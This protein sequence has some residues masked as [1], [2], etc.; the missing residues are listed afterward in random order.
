[1][2]ANPN[3]GK[4]LEDRT[5]NAFMEFLD[6]LVTEH[7]AELACHNNARQAVLDLSTHAESRQPTAALALQER[8][9][10]FFEKRRLSRRWEAGLQRRTLAPPMPS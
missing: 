5:S 9:V 7:A 1:M 10:G 2:K 3:L 6:V 4:W 8:L